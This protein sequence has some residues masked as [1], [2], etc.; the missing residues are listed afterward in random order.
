VQLGLALPQ[1]DFSVPGESPLRWETV[2]EHAR[3]AEALGFASVWLS[4]HLFWDIE[5]YGARPGRSEPFEAIVGLGAL[6]RCTT[7][8]RLGTL[9]LCEALR[10]VGVLAKALTS[11][12]RLSGGRLDVGIGAGYYAPEYEAI[13]MDLPSPGERLARLGETVDALRLLL[14]SGGEPVDFDGRFHRLHG[15]RLLPGPVQQPR[16]PVFVGGKGE[17]LLALAA[18]KADGWNTVWAWTLDAYRERVAVLD[19][20]CRRIERDPATL[21]RSLG[22]YSV[23]GEDRR[24]L[25]QRWRRMQQTAPDGMLDG[26]TLDEWRAGGRL[27][28]TVDA[29]REQVAAW[30]DL[31]VTTLIA[32]PG[33][34]PF[35]VTALDDLEPLAACVS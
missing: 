5:R 35:A 20:A 10:P 7:S 32:N 19:T 14:A 12:D 33:P 22:L 24:D 30:A 25:D 18:A 13:G 15:A 9:V 2:E 31:G 34:V 27:V 6:T 3:R 11:I 17:R 21:T 28:G 26:V 16:P 1:Y 29:V 8:V 4:D 23:V